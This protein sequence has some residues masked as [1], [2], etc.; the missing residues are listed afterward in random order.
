M[1]TLE[2]ITNTDCNLGCYYCFA[3]DKCK[4]PDP[5]NKDVYEPAIDLAYKLFKQN[6]KYKTLFF[7]L[8]GGETLLYLDNV[9]E[10]IRY[11]NNKNK[12]ENIKNVHIGIINNG[13]CITRDFVLNVKEICT[14]VRVSYNFSLEYSEDG[15]NKIR[16]Y[17]KGGKGSFDDFINNTSSIIDI[18]GKPNYQTVLSPDMLLN[19]D[20]YINMVEKYKHQGYFGLVPMFDSTFVGKEHLIKNMYKLFDYYIDCFKRNDYNHLSLFQPA[21]SI[22]ANIFDGGGHCQAGTDMFAILPNGT[23]YPCVNFY[24]NQLYDY[25]YG[26]ITDKDI[27]HKIDI[28]R[29]IMELLTKKSPECLSCQKENDIG[30]TGQCAAQ[31]IAYNNKEEVQAVCDYNINFSNETKRMI[32]ALTTNDEFHNLMNRYLYMFKGNEFSERRYKEKVMGGVV[33]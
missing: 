12:V 13:T 3:K 29:T 22:I 16:K 11:I 20:D 5:I 33:I 26:F 31:K 19:I 8:Y 15:H 18:I 1:F 7:K 25:C 17:I 21:R 28:R 14:N 10:I 30:C 4:Q 27:E 6:D 9:I 24:H 23:L 2:L 32:N